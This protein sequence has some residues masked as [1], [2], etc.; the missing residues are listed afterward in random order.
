MILQMKNN[1]PFRYDFVL[2]CLSRVARMRAGHDS[3]F[4]FLTAVEI[5]SGFHQAFLLMC[6]RWGMLFP[7]AKGAGSSI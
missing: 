1:E 6:P 4:F 5:G 7:G 3:E 2:G